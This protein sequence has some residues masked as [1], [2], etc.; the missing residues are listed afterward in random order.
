MTA[1]A[2]IVVL[3]A[4]GR[5][6][7]DS[8]ACSPWTAATRFTD[9]VAAI[10]LDAA[11]VQQQPHL[12][13]DRKT[14]YFSRVVA[15]TGFDIYAADRADPSA[16]FGDVHVV[17][18]LSS[19]QNESAFAP[20]IDELTGYISSARGGT[21]TDL[22]ISTRAQPTDPWGT[23][24]RFAGSTTFI[25]YDPFPSADG[26]RLYWMIPDWDQGVGG[27]D[28]VV[29]TRATSDDAFGPPAVVGELDTAANEDN[30]SETAD[31]RM[32]V[33]ASNRAGGMM[34]PYF[35]TRDS[36]DEPYGTPMPVPVG[37]PMLQNSET[38]VTWDGCELWFVTV[39]T[40]HQNIH[41]AEVIR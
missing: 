41:T 37:D 8:V 21:T 5:V 14:I 33:F 34:E 13:Q 7:F 29:A 16:A 20:A 39:E 15:V 28:I 35:A 10:E 30:P 17:P 11:S 9:P 12:T 19:M 23:P 6:S 31:G 27:S 2:S 40:D 1:R 36:V 38:G 18:E 32:I 4:C 3:A 22:W 25:D 26:L 24:V